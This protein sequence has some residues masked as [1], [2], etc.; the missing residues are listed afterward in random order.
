MPFRQLARALAEG[1]SADPPQY[2]LQAAF[3]F[4]SWENVE[5]RRLAG[6]L[7]REIHQTGEFDL[8]FEVMEEERDWR[9]NVKYRPGI[10]SRTN[11]ESLAARYLDLLDRIVA[12]PDFK[13]AD[14]LEEATVASDPDAA[15]S[16]DYPNRCVDELIDE[17]AAQRPD[18]VAVIFEDE[19]LTYRDLNRRANQ[20]ARHLIAAGVRPGEL[21]GVMV[22]RSLEMLISLLGVWRAGAAYVPLDPAYPTE[23]IEF[24]L[25][26]SKATVLLADATSTLRPQGVRVVTVEVERLLSESQTQSRLDTRRD[27]DSLAYVIYTS[28]ST[29]APKGVR[30]THR[31]LVH[32]LSCMADRPGCSSEDHVLALTTISFDISALELFLPLTTG[33]KVEILP[34]EMTRNGLRLKDKMEASAA[35][36]IQAT[37][38]TWKMLLAAELRKIPAV[39]AL[40]GG[41]AWDSQLAG[42]LLDRVGELW[43]MYGPT[44][45]T[46]WSSI[47][48]VERGEPVRLGEPIGNTRFYVVD[49]EMNQVKS[50]E[51]GELLIGGDG[52]ARG[53]LNRPELDRERFI[54]NPFGKSGRIYRTGDLVRNV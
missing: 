38:A 12:D 20:L 8:V 54:P 52:L 18:A 45:T 43:N 23:R 31:G 1:N 26:D 47:Q 7:M 3:Y 28:G 24:I 13:I 35:T 53:Y 39:K 41:E 46:V 27:P 30:I 5:K 9:L 29:G 25:E 42:Q 40:C 19:Q 22:N 10:Y 50:G 6:R 34:E 32:F 17:Q 49:E 15:A 48:K 11:A 2:R 4:Q 16:F 21:V 14:C 37:P 36:I 51:V 44:E 33:A